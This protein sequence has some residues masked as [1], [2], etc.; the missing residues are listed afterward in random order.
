MSFVSADYSA[1]KQNGSGALLAAPLLS[2]LRAPPGSVL[3]AGWLG[4]RAHEQAV[5]GV[6]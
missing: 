4:V 5:G 1:I 6:G 3:V 2:K